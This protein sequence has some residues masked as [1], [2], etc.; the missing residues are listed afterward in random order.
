MKIE[1]EIIS[2]QN[3]FEGFCPYAESCSESD[4]GNREICSRDCKTCGSYFLFEKGEIIVE[5][6]PPRICYESTGTF[7]GATEPYF[8][9]MF[10]G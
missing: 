6:V 2:G 8:E 3:A 1:E 9:S 5:H 4:Y 10:W 7:P